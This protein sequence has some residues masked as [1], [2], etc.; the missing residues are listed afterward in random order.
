[1]LNPQVRGLMTNQTLQMF[2][3]NQV[4]SQF[5]FGSQM[6]YI[7]P[8]STSTK[9]GAMIEMSE[10]SQ[11]EEFLEWETPIVLQAGASWCG[12]CNQLKPMVNAVAKKYEG[13]VQY[14]YMDIDKF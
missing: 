1:M 4:K 8:F 3:R 5:L 10:V 2:K 13:T 12:P 11:W 9:P 6:Q 14:V 7:K